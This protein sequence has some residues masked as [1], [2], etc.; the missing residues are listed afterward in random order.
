MAIGNL[1]VQ[2]LHYFAFDAAPPPAAAGDGLLVPI[3]PRQ[4]RSQVWPAELPNGVNGMGDELL[5][6]FCLRFGN[7]EP[8]RAT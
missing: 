3:W 5:E 8:A 7:P 1:I 2:F 4:G 6:R